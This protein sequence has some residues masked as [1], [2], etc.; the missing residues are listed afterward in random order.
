MN[1]AEKQKNSLINYFKGGFENGMKQLRV[2]DVAAATADLKAALKVNNRISFYS[3]RNGTADLRVSQIEAI[4]SVF[5]K[6]G[7][8]HDIWGS[9]KQNWF[10]TSI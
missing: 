10:T 4:E 6:Y 1:T 7:I 5:A 9:D 2:C 3:Y 8:E